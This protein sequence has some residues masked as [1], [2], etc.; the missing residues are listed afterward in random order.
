M[1]RLGNLSFVDGLKLVCW[2]RQAKLNQV[3]VDKEGILQRQTVRDQAK[4]G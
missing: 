4:R 3:G 1:E 2:P